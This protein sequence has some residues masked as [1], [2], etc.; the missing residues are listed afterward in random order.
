MKWKS[1]YKLFLPLLVPVQQSLCE[2]FHTSGFNNWPHFKRSSRLVFSYFSLNF[3]QNLK[4]MIMIYLY[5][6]VKMWTKSYLIKNNISKYKRIYI[7][8]ELTVKKNW[9][10][11]AFVV[12]KHNPIFYFIFASVSNHFHIWIFDF[13]LRSFGFLLKSN[14]YCF[15]LVANW[16]SSQL[17]PQPH[18]ELNPKAETLHWLSPRAIWPRVSPKSEYTGLVGEINK[19]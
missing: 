4:N 3:E 14:D 10:F 19:K 2:K 7:T 1:K 9:P 5:F 12:S 17:R 15:A 11:L 13:S 16:N 8:F 18:L 6:I